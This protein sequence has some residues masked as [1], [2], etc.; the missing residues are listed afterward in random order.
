MRTAHTEPTIEEVRASILETKKTGESLEGR[1]PLVASVITGICSVTLQLLDAYVAQT[2]AC[3]R[4]EREVEELRHR[5][6]GLEK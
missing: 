2:E 1:D 3:A 4:A 6:R 5:L